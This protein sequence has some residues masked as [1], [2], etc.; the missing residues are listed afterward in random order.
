MRGDWH[1]PRCIFFHFSRASKFHT[2][3]RF[4]K[5]RF[6]R[7][8]L[9]EKFFAVEVTQLKFFHYKKYAFLF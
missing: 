3:A 7:Q 6:L 8:F 1:T 5:F 2:R 9:F 4:P